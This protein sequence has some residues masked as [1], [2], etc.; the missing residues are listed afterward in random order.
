MRR[1]RTISKPVEWEGVGI[2]TG[3]EVRMCLTPAPPDHGVVFSLGG[4]PIPAAV[5][6]VSPGARNTS[7]E[8]DGAVVYTVEHILAALYGTGID[9]AVIELS[10]QE[11]PAMDGS[12]LPFVESILK[13][14]AEEQDAERRYVAPASSITVESGDANITI[15]PAAEFRIAYFMHYEHPMLRNLTFDFQPDAESFSRQVAPARTF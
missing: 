3:S 2:H 7:L 5:E 4:R 6:R 8:A 13:A 9:N 12:A 15:L 10:A 1:Q 14:G 11:P